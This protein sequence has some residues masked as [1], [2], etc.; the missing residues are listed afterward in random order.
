MLGKSETILSIKSYSCPVGVGATTTPWEEAVAL[1][2]VL[3]APRMGV[4]IT[5][6]LELDDEVAEDTRCFCL[7]R[8]EN[9]SSFSVD[10]DDGVDD[11]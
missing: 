4:W 11:D 8:R 3:E 1:S 6:L 5:L 2:S 7:S 9:A 10:T